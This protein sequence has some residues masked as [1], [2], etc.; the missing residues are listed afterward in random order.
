MC[1]LK[2]HLV[3]LGWVQTNVGECVPRHPEQNGLGASVSVQ[4]ASH[5]Y[6]QSETSRNGSLS[7]GS[8]SLGSL[9][10]LAVPR[11]AVSRLAVSARCLSARCLSARCLGS[12]AW[13]AVSRLAVSRLAVSRTVAPQQLVTVEFLLHCPGRLL[14]LRLIL[15]I[16]Q[17]LHYKIHLQHA[18]AP[19]AY[20][21][22]LGSLLPTAPAAYCA[23]VPGR[24]ITSAVRIFS[25]C[26]IASRVS[27]HCPALAARRAQDS[28]AHGPVARPAS[29]AQAFHRD[30]SLAAAHS[31]LRRLRI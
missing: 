22:W 31:T 5:F 19:A 9:S 6:T 29:H 4:S 17:R 11:L 28:D 26:S 23:S 7:L 21:A 30:P 13:L 27:V 10:R 14:R 18:T 24:E 16:K 3:A 15:L 1:P 12:L 25:W 20:C 8:L 2:T